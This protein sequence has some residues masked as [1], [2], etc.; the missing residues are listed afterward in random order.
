MASLIFQMFPHLPLTETST[1]S[2]Y[3]DALDAA[4][5]ERASFRFKLFLSALLFVVFWLLGGAVFSA[6]E[7]T[8][9]YP[10][11]LYFC[12]NSMAGIGYGDYTPANPLSKSMF[13]FWILLGYV[14]LAFFG[15]MIG[16]AVSRA[17]SGGKGVEQR[18]KVIE[19]E[20]EEKDRRNAQEEDLERGR[21]LS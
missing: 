13:C 14:C 11:G 21:I 2:T 6:L 10:A 1:I 7:P 16:E 12:W 17:L 18:R 3:T 5:A 4:A 15:S 8:W 9:S 19:L 20:E